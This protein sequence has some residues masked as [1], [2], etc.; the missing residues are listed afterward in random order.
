M[1]IQTSITDEKPVDAGVSRDD[2]FEM[3][4]NT[5]RRYVV[6]YLEGEEAADLGDLSRQ[7]AA[8]ENGI[9]RRE[10][11]SDQR[12]RVYTAL[13]QSHLPRMDRTEFVEFDPDRGVVEATD[14]LEDLTVYMQV[15]PDD[16]IPW[17]VFNGGVALVL[18]GLMA[19]GAAGVPPFETMPGYAW[20]IA[21]MGAFFLASVAQYLHERR[22]RLGGEGLPP[23]AEGHGPAGD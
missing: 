21:A 10:V 20:A 19:V 18:A 16:E 7:V 12:K 1:S 4:S 6:H 2:A 8:W 3:L 15:V 17:S 13:R 9:D 14:R 5:R 23:S 11:T 22:H